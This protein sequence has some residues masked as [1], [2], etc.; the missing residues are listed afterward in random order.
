MQQDCRTCYDDNMTETEILMII[1]DHS[2]LPGFR[3]NIGGNRSLMV[4]TILNILPGYGLRMVITPLSYNIGCVIHPQKEDVVISS[5]DDLRNIIKAR[6]LE[7]GFNKE[8]DIAVLMGLEYT[9][10]S[11]L[12]NGKTNFSLKQLLHLCDMLW[13]DVKIEDIEQRKTPAVSDERSE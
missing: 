4:Q 2:S 8:K 11:K 5:P 1:H 9:Y 6:R 10:Y 7:L 13:L 3:G 12:E